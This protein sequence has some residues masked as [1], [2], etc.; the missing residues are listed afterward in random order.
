MCKEIS[1]SLSNKLNG[2]FALKEIAL[3]SYR[4]AVQKLI[5]SFSST[6]LEHVSQIPNKHTDALATLALK[7]GVPDEVVDVRIMKRRTLRA[8]AVD[9]IPDN[10]IG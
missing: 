1:S 5:R 9:L 8:T 7:V 2:E 3:V 6:C 4:T 10:F